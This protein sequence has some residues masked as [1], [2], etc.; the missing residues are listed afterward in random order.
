MI[1]RKRNVLSELKHY[2]RT[3]PLGCF[4]VIVFVPVRNAFWNVIE[5]FMLSLS[6]FE[7]VDP[8]KHQLQGQITFIPDYNPHTT[9]TKTA[10]GGN[11][12]QKTPSIPDNQSVTS[13]CG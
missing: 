11:N 5:V 12:R 8:E 4:R 9:V 3:L 10:P 7:C 2:V 6:P 1:F 13:F